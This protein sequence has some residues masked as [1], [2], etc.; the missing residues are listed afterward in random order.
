M[1]LEKRGAA[2]IE[3]D[4]L[5]IY[6]SEELA[7]RARVTNISLR[8]LFLSSVTLDHEGRA[9]DL[10]LTIPGLREILDLDG[11]VVWGRAI[12]RPAGMGITFN[13]PDP[14]HRLALANFL[15][16]HYQQMVF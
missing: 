10:E 5:A 15:L 6:R 11:E 14:S 2:R 1:D 16:A 8:G 4:L 9:A 12:P 3:V 13:L 7:L